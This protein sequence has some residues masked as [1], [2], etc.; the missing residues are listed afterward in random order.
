[1]ATR[2]N[3]QSALIDNYVRELRV[4]SD[5]T[6]RWYANEIHAFYR[7]VTRTTMDGRPTETTVIAWIRERMT[8]VTEI[9][10]Y[11][12]ARKIHGYLQYLVEQGHEGSNPFAELCKR[13]GERFLAPIL[14]AA[15]AAEPAKAFAGLIRPAPWSSSIGPIMRDHV[16]LMRSVGYRYVPQE[17]RYRS[18]DR[19]LQSQPQLAGQP[20]ETLIKAW[21]DAKPT[22][23]H[24]G[25]CELVGRLLGRA[26]H[27]LDP[28]SQAVDVDRGLRRRLYGGHRRPY[29]YSVEE[30]TRLFKAARALQAPRSPLLPATVYTMLVLAYCAGLRLGE[31]GHLTI[32]DVDISAGLLTVRN[33]KFFKSRQVPLDPSATQVLDEYLTARRRAG[34]PANAEASFFWHEARQNGYSR[35]AVANLL[36]RALRAAGLKPARG[37]VGPRVHDLRHAFVVHRLLKW[38]EEGVDPE[39][40]LP[41]LATYLGHKSIHST[42]IYITVTRELMQHAAERFRRRGAASLRTE[43]GTT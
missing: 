43:G 13:H 6:R 35:A 26:M 1:M 38:Y 21:A 32:R 24:R 23:G 19:F 15:A 8:K 40:R 36:V 10:V 41:H 20:L 11:D 28:Q 3:A 12:R 37:K 34:G 39:P 25:Q 4:R 42:L 17:S 22:K 16:A 31:L 29:I 14:R 7:F 2:C 18:F 33:T 5:Q 27:R 30:L 9:V